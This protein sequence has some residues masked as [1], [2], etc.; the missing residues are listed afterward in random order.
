MSMNWIIFLASL[1]VIGS[2]LGLTMSGS[3]PF[4]QSNMD[5]ANSMV[6]P[7]ANPV[8]FIGVFFTVVTMDYDFFNHPPQLQIL[9]FICLAPI[10]IAVGYAVVIFLASFFTG[11]G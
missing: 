9:R 4:P 5:T 7:Q 1:W 8:N 11:G 2:I 10:M 6:K 3:N